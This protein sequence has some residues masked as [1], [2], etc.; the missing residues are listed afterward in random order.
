MMS[1]LDFSERPRLPPPSS[2]F[3][4]ADYSP[5]S[6]GSSG[7]V[8]GTGG[9]R[10]RPMLPSPSHAL[11]RLPT[12]ST[13]PPPPMAAVR[14]RHYESLTPAT[15]L[16]PPS[17]VPT[18]MPSAYHHHRDVAPLPHHAQPI[19]QA[20]NGGNAHHVHDGYH[21]MP[22]RPTHPP[23][24][25]PPISA[26]GTHG[27][28]WD[29]PQH[30][31][32]GDGSGSSN[33]GWY[34]MG[35]SVSSMLPRKRLRNSRSC[36]ECQRRKTRCDA[37]GAFPGEA[38]YTGTSPPSHSNASEEDMIVVQPCTNCVRSGVDCQ[39][40]R[41]PAKRGPSKGYIKDLETR[42]N[43]LQQEQ[44]STAA[45]QE[46]RRLSESPS[47][48]GEQLPLSSRQT[49]MARTSISSHHASCFSTSPISRPSRPWE[50]A[51]EMNQ[52]PRKRPHE[53]VPDTVEEA[54]E[55]D[56]LEAPLPE[57]VRSPDSEAAETMVELSTEK[58]RREP[59]EQARPVPVEKLATPVTAS[60]TPLSTATS[61]MRGFF[62]K[63]E[64]NA[65]FAIRPFNVDEDT[66]MAGLN[67][68]LV[69]RAMKLCLEPASPPL[70][71][72]GNISSS[73]STS[74]SAAKDQKPHAVR[75]AQLQGSAM[76]GLQYNRA[77]GVLDAC[78]SGLIAVRA[79]RKMAAATAALEADALL[80]CYLDGLRQGNTDSSPLAAASSKIA[81]TSLS[82]Q[83]SRDAARRR[84]VL[85][86]VDRWHAFAFNA[87][88]VMHERML[89]TGTLSHEG[90][91]Q[92][93]GDLSANPLETVPA[94]VMRCALMFGSLNDL[95]HQHG[96]WKNVTVDDCE[97]IIHS[98]GASEDDD[99]AP[100]SS[101]SDSPPG[102]KTI[103]SMQAFRYSLRGAVRLYYRMQTL[104]H[105][106]TT[107]LKTVS[108]LVEVLEECIL[109]GKARTPVDPQTL[110][111]RSY[112]GPHIFA[113]AACALLW[114]SR[115]V[116]LLGKQRYEG[117]RDPS[118][119]QDDDGT[120]LEYLR[121]LV[122]D[123]SR[124]IGSLTFFASTSGDSKPGCPPSVRPL[125]LRIAAFNHHATVSY[126][127]ALGKVSSASAEELPE[128]SPLHDSLEVLREEV[129][130]RADFFAEMGPLGLVLATTT[131]KE[132]WAMIGQEEGML[133][134]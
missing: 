56:E 104:P 91:I 126:F 71:S 1:R 19:S 41:R 119:Q 12:A 102:T 44:T 107:T 127:A 124:M 62:V 88:H 46:E 110:L 86:A 128:N 111:M 65:T 97:S 39:Y 14:E 129:D 47:S 49:S 134:V 17:L 2:L 53:E 33:S 70:G 94:E 59:Q 115:A 60:T 42:L 13:L 11:P 20:W 61:S 114:L 125:Y 130:G 45:S 28:A 3:R 4:H 133:P 103:Y 112:V 22:Q 37:V 99:P 69:T 105:S 113:L 54:E 72:V 79:A 50:D 108:T 89:P 68:R 16:Q 75:L 77:D 10:H 43:T 121:R 81:A 92:S 76:G 101:S 83:L 106:T 117:R 51:T 6:G 131:S 64:V 120:Q 122:Q 116:T 5:P 57:A 84:C 34:G 82:G 96:G 40:S 38:G 98:C 36:A 35:S 31:D 118:R 100:T 7:A 95:A 18:G 63:S 85:F 78:S 93:L 109:A 58:L 132:A 30:P 67:D 55:V 66:D 15:P 9:E 8:G 27:F 23:L 80:L 29:A 24:P 21:H 25:T 48:R 123:Y 32:M 52:T 90:L 87:P 73:S 26:H 74:S